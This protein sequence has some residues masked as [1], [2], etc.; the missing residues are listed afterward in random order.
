MSA[1]QKTETERMMTVTFYRQWLAFPLSKMRGDEPD[2]IMVCVSPNGPDE[3]GNYEFLVKH[4][5]TESKYREAIALR[6]DM[7]TDSWRAFR[8]L[9]E[10]FDLL[11]ELDESD[12]AGRSRLTLDDLIPSLEVMGWRDRTEEFAANHEHSWGCLGCGERK[13]ISR[14]GESA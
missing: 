3:G 13:P 11:A 9:P 2:T 5:G 14:S 4:V 12:A 1:E 6:V 8:D 7:F 10:F